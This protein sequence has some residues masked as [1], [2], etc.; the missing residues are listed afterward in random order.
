MADRQVGFAEQLAQRR[1]FALVWL[2]RGVMLSKGHLRPDDADEVVGRVGGKPG[3]IIFLI[4]I[5]DDPD[6]S[7]YAACKGIAV[8]DRT[9]AIPLPEPVMIDA[10]DA[11]MGRLA[12]LP[13]GAHELRLP[14]RAELLSR[15]ATMIPDSI[16]DFVE[17][18]GDAEPKQPPSFGFS[19]RPADAAAIGRAIALAR[20]RGT[21]FDPPLMLAM[22]LR[23]A[24]LSHSIDSAGFV[25]RWLATGRPI[26]AENREAFVAKLFELD[27]SLTPKADPRQALDTA[28]PQESSLVLRLD[29]AASVIRDRVSPQRELYTRHILA[30]LVGAKP[31]ELSAAA[32][33]EARGVDVAELRRAMA[34]F[35]STARP[36][37]SL[38]SWNVA[39]G[40]VSG[41]DIANR[42]TTDIWTRDD[43]LGYAKYAQAIADSI[44][45]GNTPPPL[46]IGIQAPWGQG[47]TSLMRMI[48]ARLDPAAVA[49]EMP[50][51]AATDAPSGVLS[52][53]GDFRA[54]L[55]RRNP[56]EKDG[57]L[58]PAAGT[59][60]T[61]WF[62]PLYYRET[63]QVWAGLAH[64]ILHQLVEQLPTPNRREEFWL[65]LQ[66]SRVNVAAIRRDVH[67][68]LLTHA[69]PRGAFWIAVGAALALMPLSLEARIFGAGGG[70]LAA[71]LHFWSVIE[72]R[73]LDRP[74]EKYVTEPSYQ[75][76]LGLLHLVDHDLDRALRLLVGSRPVAVFI[77]DLDRCD[78]QTV[79][80]IILAINQFLSL[81]N[82]NVY[83][84][85]GMDM[86]MVAAALEQAQK[87]THGAAAARRSFGWRFMEKF[88][89]LPFV[90]PH[91]D[92]DT[93]RRFAVAHLGKTVHTE[94]ARPDRLS[95]EETLEAVE[96][97]Q[98]PA[99]IGR[100][101]R[102][103]PSM[104][105]DPA[106]MARLEEQFSRRTTQ[107]M[108][109]P[110]SDE[111][112]RIVQIAIDDLDLNPRTMK[113]YFCLVRLLR[114]I[115]IATGQVMNAD[116]DRKL[117]LRGAHLLLNWPQ[118]VQWLRSTG[119]KTMVEKLDETAASS[120]TPAEW[121]DS[122]KTALG[123]APPAFLEDASLHLYL[124][125][126]SGDPPGLT[127]MYATRIF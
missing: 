74:F 10:D 11:T 28:T 15:I 41:F 16:H 85:L 39:L 49:R 52:T 84:I 88:I 68:W 60:P 62:N 13:E 55:R 3:E 35:L 69:V 38:E 2:E 14:E 59:L 115:Q 89:Q 56:D 17:M 104:E 7:R 45:I 42:V 126:L 6:G 1:A 105:F 27:G 58:Q 110:T 122:I 53:Y 75:T 102:Q 81:P 40:V 101:A 19:F 36:E 100:I 97:A 87:E 117:V 50:R 64:A 70:A 98:S 24:D 32:A 103:L 96:R 120:E 127:T 8:L 118:F 72:K 26:T 29:R 99:E 112:Q 23:H 71:A 119:N 22:F 90:I 116:F 12:R 92:P 109:D 125:R 30:V 79:N 82:R 46:T 108:Q 47:K 61:V 124:R 78:P 51:S 18:L 106:D 34:R 77:D 4:A 83:F 76:E 113:R 57:M 123:V 9:R 5:Q 37:E 44:L 80:Q 43:T 25:L 48:Q 73:T 33:L 111:V 121:I 107:L 21:P 67:L 54:W 93:A 65:R 86:E 31:P 94:E 95:V 114:N 20:E 66:M 91:L 63:S